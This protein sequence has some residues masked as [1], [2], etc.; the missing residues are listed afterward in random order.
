VAPIPDEGEVGDLGEVA[1]IVVGGYA[2]ACC[3]GCVQGLRGGSAVKI[4]GDVG[5]RKIVDCVEKPSALDTWDLRTGI[6]LE[7]MQWVAS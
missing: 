6:G 4:A 1:G 3:D 5:T 2:A 7:E